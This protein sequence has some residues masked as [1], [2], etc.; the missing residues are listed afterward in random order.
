[1]TISI[2]FLALPLFAPVYPSLG[3]PDEYTYYGVV[4]SKIYRYFLNDWDATPTNWEDLDSGWTIGLS[5]TAYLQGAVGLNGTL[6]A[7]K[8]LL[9]IVAAE[10]DTNVEVY[11][12]ALGSLLSEGQVSS[13]G[14]HFV[15]LPNSTHF[16]VVSDKLVSVLLL[17]YQ[18][19]PPAVVSEGPLPHGFYTSTDGLYVGTEFVFMASQSP[20]EQDHVIL[21]LENAEVTVTRDDGTANTY[22]LEANSYREL[23][24]RSFRVYRIE[25]TGNIMVQSGQITGKGAEDTTCFLV[26]SAEGGFVGQFFVTRSFKSQEWGWDPLRDYGFRITA[27]EDTEVKVYDL[28]TKEEMMTLDVKGGSG[29]AFHPEAIAIAVQSDK[30]VTLS[31]IHNDS[32]EHGPT[33]AGG[34]FE[35]YGNGVMFMGIQPDEDTMV[36][37]P[38]EAYVEA[39]FFASE[40]TQITIDGFTH[41][42]QADSGLLYTMPGTHRVRSDNNV[43]LQVNL[44]PR[45]PEFQGLWYRGA[46]IPCIETVGNNP[47]VTLTPIG[48]GFPMMYVMIG[49]GAAAVAVIAGLLVMKRRGGKPSYNGWL[50]NQYALLSDENMNS[51]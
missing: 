17:N 18:E 14:K 37:L 20:T 27:L 12:L 38:T 43:I 8:S 2:I 10:D 6:V 34:R 36:H 39:Y 21:A 24:L 41:T 19:S 32:I 48:G 28:Q 40:E 23:M 3:D 47:E 15:F 4:P 45:E 25:S 13:M 1:M 26:P 30:P 42:I 49:A 9:A 16:K 31:H 29:V 33:G 22:S 7:T 35:G 46:A 5:N 11:D 51:K 44:W 50:V